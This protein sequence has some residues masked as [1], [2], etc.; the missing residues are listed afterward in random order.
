MWHE[1]PFVSYSPTTRQA[2]GEWAKM[3]ASEDLANFLSHIVKKA[4]RG[5]EARIIIDNY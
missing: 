2:I 3:R 1:Q 4:L 5:E